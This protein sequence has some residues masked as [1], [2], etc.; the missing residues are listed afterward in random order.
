[1]QNGLLEITNEGKIYLASFC[2]NSLDAILGEVGG[3]KENMLKF[4]L[5]S[6]SSWRARF[7]HTEA[8]REKLMFFCK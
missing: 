7:K 8:G 6:C 4:N 3:A 1:L 2:N 5:F